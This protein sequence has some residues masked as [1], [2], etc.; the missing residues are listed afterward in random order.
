[1]Q[2]VR[3]AQLSQH[4]LRWFIK[5]S[6]CGS[7]PTGAS[8][9]SKICQRG[10]NTASVP[11]L[12]SLKVTFSELIKQRQEKFG[13]HSTAHLKLDKTKQAIIFMLSMPRTLE[14]A[15]PKQCGTTT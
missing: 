1:V 2:K 5:S 14:I 6:P 13:K 10:C 7:H 3:K 8:T 4:L 11:K 15:S 9:E 12:V